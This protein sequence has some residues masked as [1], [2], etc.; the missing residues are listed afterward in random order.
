MEPGDRARPRLLLVSDHRAASDALAEYLTLHGFD[1]VARAS[2]ATEAARAVR[3]VPV[4]VALVDGDLPAGWLAVVCALTD[5]LGQHRIAVLSS[6]WGERERRDARE[7]GIGA[8]LLKRIAG[9][10][11]AGQLRALAA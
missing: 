4:D 6:Y 1:V 2:N 7:C 8:T 10:I 11:L 9:P 3:D 5:T